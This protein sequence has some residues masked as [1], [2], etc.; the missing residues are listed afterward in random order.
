MFNLLVFRNICF[1]LEKNKIDHDVITKLTGWENFE[2]VVWLQLTWRNY[3]HSQLIK[4]LLLWMEVSE[5]GY[6]LIR[7]ETY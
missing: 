6:A 5:A 4:M 3:T 7:C 2:K 1:S